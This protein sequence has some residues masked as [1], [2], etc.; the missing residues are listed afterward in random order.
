MGKPTICIGENKG[1]DQLHS[2][3]EADQRLCFAT[4]IVPFLYFINPKFP[5]SS[6]L[7]CL[8]S[9]VRVELVWKPHCWFSHE[10]AHLC[11]FSTICLIQTQERDLFIWMGL[12]I[13]SHGYVLV[14]CWSISVLIERSG[15]QIPQVL[16][17]TETL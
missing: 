8:H 4:W 13:V 3:C 9:S 16:S 6:H 5:A 11:L 2:N 15:F 12:L 10:M 1:A 7:L 14:W 17:S